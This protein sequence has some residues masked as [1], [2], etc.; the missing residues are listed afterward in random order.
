LRVVALFIVFVIAV[1]A[2]WYYVNGGHR[3]GNVSSASVTVYYTAPDGAS[4]ESYTVTLGPARDLHSVAFYAATQAV[5]GPPQ[6]VDAI[7]F[8]TGTHVRS[9]D[10]DGSTAIVDLSSDVNNV[11]GGSFD[12][13]GMFKS[14]VW[15]LTAIHGI[16]SVSIRVEGA[17]VATLHGGHLE[18]DE[19]LSR[20]SW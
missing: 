15:T 11:G 18:L 6:N 14:L 17:R 1:A 19:P 9:V 4:E 16:D 13:G 3:G 5:A 20:S 10:L 12:E 2:G 7:R 8:P